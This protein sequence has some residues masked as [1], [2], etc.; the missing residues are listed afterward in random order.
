MPTINHTPRQRPVAAALDQLLTDAEVTARAIEDNAHEDR[1][2]V[3][4]LALSNWRRRLNAINDALHNA[5]MVTPSYL[6]TY[7]S[8]TGKELH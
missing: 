4:F 8:C 7:P 2:P 3:D 1:K 6:P 5:S